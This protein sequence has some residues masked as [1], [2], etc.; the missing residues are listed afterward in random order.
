MRR[1]KL[2]DGSPASI[3]A[4]RDWLDPIKRASTV[5]DRLRRRRR[6]FNVCARASFVS[7]HAAS[8]LE[9]L[10][11]SP[12]VPTFQPAASRRA[13]FALFIDHPPINQQNI[14]NHLLRCSPRRFLKN[15][16]NHDGVMVYAVYN[17]PIAVPVSNAQLVATRRNLRH[18]TRMRQR[19]PFTLLK[20]PQHIPCFDTRL[21]RKRWRLDCINAPN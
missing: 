3:F 14:F 9:R 11:N 17:P 19:K 12:A 18:W 5:C 21:G 10:R 1:S 7:T 13:F 2:T 20:S 6:S 15:L 16:W 8:S 4:T